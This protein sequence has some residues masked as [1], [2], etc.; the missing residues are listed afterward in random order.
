MLESALRCNALGLSVF[1]LFRRG[2]K[3]AVE[4]MRFQH[5]RPTEAQIKSWW[6][7][8]PEANIAVACGPVSGVL[9]VDVDGE[10]GAAT[11]A[12]LQQTY[13]PL[14]ATWR[15]STGKGEHLWFRYPQG[16][17]IGNARG[18]LKNSGVDIR[19]FGGYVVAPGSIHENGTPYAWQ[20]DCDPNFLPV[21]DIPAWFLDLLTAPATPEKP[22]FDIRSVEGAEDRY[23]AAA[24]KGEVSNVLT[25]KEGERN[26]TLNVAAFK[27]AGF[28]TA[29]MLT[30]TEVRAALTGAARAIGLIDSEIGPTIDSGLAAGLQHPREVP[31]RPVPHK[32]Q[33]A[34]LKVVQPAMAETTTVPEEES[35][36]PQFSDD[37]LALRFTAK[38]CEEL[39]YTATLNRWHIWKEPG[40]WRAD[41]TMASWSLAR[42]ICRDAAAEA[43]SL[44]PKQSSMFKGIASNK[45]VAAVVSMARYDR[46]HASAVD[47]WDADPWK[48]N[49][50]AGIV[51][52]KDGQL[53]PHD[54]QE[55]CTK[56]TSVGPDTEA[57]GCPKWLGFLRTVTDGNTALIDYLQRVCGYCLTGTTREHALFFLYGTGANGKSVFI[58]TVSGVL[59][60]YH[61]VAPIEIFMES[62]NDRHP[63]EIAM[64][65]G[66]R[67]VTAVETEEGRRWAESKLKNLTGGDKLTAHFMRQDYFEFVP[68]F[69]LLIA[70]NHK[71]AIRSVDEAIRRRLNLIPFTVTIPA[72][73]RDPDLAE[74]LRAEYPAILSW[75][76][77]GCQQWQTSGL[78]PP[79]TVRKATDDYLD[80]EDAIMTWVEACCDRSPSAFETTTA[81]FN[82]WKSWA[83]RNNE[84]AGGS[85][86]FGQALEQHGFRREKR[87]K[88]NGFIG[89]NII[90]Q[91]QDHIGEDI[92]NG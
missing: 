79:D 68:Q 44:S 53:S 2:K 92:N 17:E 87:E 69:K 65:M 13:G 4:W 3:A 56:S 11:I 7:D 71:P 8:R 52:L 66:A 47:Q 43:E 77:A 74:K 67:L 55:Y 10:K 81:L 1:P 84:P 80:A 62:K 21:S 40:V 12:H 51:D 50:A 31:E 88:G 33:R 34:M 83:E 70:G 26:N 49:T 18:R 75:M 38:H 9:V 58:N 28:V 20:D 72:E 5:E 24:F 19:G 39:R 23:I 48:L 59:A 36:P 76:I 27:L 90:F 45:T 85:K 60:D 35:L 6:L 46:R 63:T 15:S 32:P 30:E 42:Q 29:G 91:R 82:S 16:L 73:K 25:A 86:R 64:L 89:L 41:E 14:P 22:D 78:N 57:A 61:R 54:P 37:H